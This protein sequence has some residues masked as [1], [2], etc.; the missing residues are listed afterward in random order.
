MKYPVLPKKYWIQHDYLLYAYDILGDMLRQADDKKLSNIILKFKN[1]NQGTSF[2]KSEDKLLWM[3]KNGYHDVAVK[4]FSNHMFFSLLRDFCYYIYESISCAGRGKV[5]VAYTLLRK[6][7]RDNLLYL[8]WVLADR[9][10]FFDTFLYKEIKYYDISNYKVFS[11][12]RIQNIIDEASKKSYMGKALNYNNLVYTFRFNS[13]EQIG[14]QRI[15]NQS[16]HLVTKSPNYETQQGNLNFVF[17]DAKVWNDFWDYYYFV[18]P[19]LMAYVLEICEALFITTIDVN[20]VELKFNR[21]I[22]LAKY[23]N[24]QI[25]LKSLQEIKDYTF[26]LFKM[27]ED[28]KIHLSFKCEKCCKDIVFSSKIIDEMIKNQFIFCPTCNQEHNICKY[29][30]DFQY[31]QKTD[32]KR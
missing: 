21:A 10:E 14:L 8:E 22:R 18:M 5:T 27:F 7:M 17:A 15:W 31:I 11:K 3:D 9:Q 4:M 23:A 26:D 30:T 6:P 29:Y 25:E 2:N 24:A 19:Q 16:M 12:D 20:E 1:K 32:I 28:S 13:E